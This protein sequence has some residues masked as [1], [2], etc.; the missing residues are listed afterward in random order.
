MLLSHN[1]LALNF[2]KI[3]QPTWELIGVALMFQLPFQL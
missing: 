3:H 1:L 2:F